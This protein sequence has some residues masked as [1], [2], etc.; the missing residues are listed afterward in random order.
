MP[1]ADASGN[2]SKWTTMSCFVCES[3]T[4][5]RT[6]HALLKLVL[7]ETFNPELFQCFHDNLGGGFA[8]L[9]GRDV[10]TTANIIGQADGR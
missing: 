10:Q 5:L 7:A 9:P 4:S 2:L 6:C 8:C 1:E 3:L